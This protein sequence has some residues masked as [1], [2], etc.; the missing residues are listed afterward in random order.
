MV[1]WHKLQ[2]LQLLS[3]KEFNAFWV[4]LA[5]S[6]LK[7]FGLAVMIF[8]FF[9]S[10]PALWNPK[11]MLVLPQRV[12]LCMVERSVHIWWAELQI[13]K[14]KRQMLFHY[15]ALLLFLKIKGRKDW[16][17]AAARHTVQAMLTCVAW[18]TCAEE[19]LLS[20]LSFQPLLVVRIFSNSRNCQL[21]F[22]LVI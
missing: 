11:E 8:L 14:I 22:N 15:R 6:G 13:L 7:D 17:R 20:V 12:V 4:V 18:G 21:V 3:F 9:F 5:S 16:K 10:H 19:M 2:C 1:N